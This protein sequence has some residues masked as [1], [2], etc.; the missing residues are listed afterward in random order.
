MTSLI[1]ITDLQENISLQIKHNI[2]NMKLVKKVME[3]FAEKGLNEDTPALLFNQS[4]DVKDIDCK[5]DKTEL[6]CLTKS[7]HEYLSK[8]FENEIL[9]P[10]K[11][12]SSPELTTYKN[13]VVVEVESI[14][15]VIKF[16][17]TTQVSGKIYSTYISAEYMSLLRKNRKYAN[18]QGIQRPRKKVRAKNGEEYEVISA[19]KKGILELRDR[20][21]KQDIFPTAVSFAILQEGEKKPKFSFI[22]NIE[23]EKIGTLSIIPNFNIEDDEYTPFIIV[24]GYHR[25]TALADSW[26]VAEVDNGLFAIIAI[27]TEEE[28]KQYVVD[29]LNRNDVEN[30]DELDA[31][32][33]TTEEKFVKNLILNSRILN[34]NVG[35]VFKEIEFNDKLTYNKILEK[36]IQRTNFKLDD[37]IDAEYD[38]EKA[39][40]IIDSIIIRLQKDYFEDSLDKLKETYLLKPNTFVGYLAIASKLINNPRYKAIVGNI[41]DELYLKLE[42]NNLLIDKFKL[43][44]EKCNIKEIYNYFDEIAEVAINE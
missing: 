29:S 44:S 11:Y 14:P 36:T 28:A 2:G 38:A 27:M 37:E 25:T 30:K 13:F 41:V 18:Y 34:S 4:L 7:M 15:K 21:I 35:K 24:D 6:I 33:P 12:F 32:L 8:N 16:E 39:S 9:K 3:D 22:P 43:D 10:E 26:D 20:F 17:N 23:G 40:R 5:E 42:E 1:S 19:N 31:M